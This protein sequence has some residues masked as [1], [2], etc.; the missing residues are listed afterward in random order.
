[1]VVRQPIPLHHLHSFLVGQMIELTGEDG[2]RF[3]KQIEYRQREGEQNWDANLGL[4]APHFLKAFLVALDKVR[5]FYD[6][7]WETGHS[8]IPESK[9][10]TTFPFEIPKI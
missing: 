2:R 3:R 6:V 5:T 1:M 10:A 9:S 8:F 4:A 7:Q